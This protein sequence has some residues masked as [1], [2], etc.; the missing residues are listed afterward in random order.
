[1]RKE[2]KDAIVK[3][4]MLISVAALPLLAYFILNL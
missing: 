2:I 1:M 3:S 4:Y